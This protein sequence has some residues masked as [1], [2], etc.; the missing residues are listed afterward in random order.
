MCIVVACRI[1]LCPKNCSRLYYSNRKIN[2]NIPILVKLI[3]FYLLNDTLFRLNIYFKPLIRAVHHFECS[4]KSSYTRTFNAIYHASIHVIHT[5]IDS[6][7]DCAFIH[8]YNNQKFFYDISFHSI[9]QNNLNRTK[10][11]KKPKYCCEYC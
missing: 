1:Y 7:T 5:A 11:K 10:K 4:R 9:L 2:Q 8:I 6:Q 3:I